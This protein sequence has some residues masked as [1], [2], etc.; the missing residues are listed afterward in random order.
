MN[1]ISKFLNKPAD[2]ISKKDIINFI[3]VKNIRIINFRYIAQDGRLKTLNFPAHDLKYVDRILSV[4]ERV[5][6]SS[7]FKGISHSSSDLYVVPLYQTVF[8]NPFYEVPAIDII[9]NFFN[10]DGNLFESAPDNI[11]RKAVDSF[12]NKTGYDIQVFGELEY[13]VISQRNDLYPIM[14]Q[15]GYHESYPFNKWEFLRVEALDLISKTGAAVKYAHSEVGF[16]RSE[17]KEMIQNEIEFLP[18]SPI[19]AAYQLLIAKWIL[20]SLGNKYGVIVS[21]APKISIG[22]AGSGLHIHSCITKNG[23][24]MMIKN[25]TLSEEAKKLIY[26]MLKVA[27]SSTA[28]GN[29][30]PTSYLRLVP[31]QEAPVKICWG[32][33][34]R[35]ALVRVP[36]GFNLDKNIVSVINK[37]ADNKKYSHSQTVEFRAGDGSAYIPLFIASLVCGAKYGFM[38]KSYNDVEKY[39]ISD[40]TK[41]DFDRLP[42]SCYESADE[43]IKDRSIYEDD[44]VFSKEVIELTYKKLKSYDDKN[45]NE[46]LYG[47]EEEIKKIVEQY[48]YC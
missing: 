8:E 30:F 14:A 11:L 26:G 36:L 6:G 34:N 22:H 20:H 31:G 33:R 38:D 25:S 27:K 5:D 7:L 4:G 12:K 16:I 29:I 44:A 28:F 9:C 40:T 17:D 1:T 42:S 48:L 43:L 47:K 39:Y 3:K 41:S 46:K 24:N 13:Y 35:N 19:S 15:K 23:K 2:N 37:I 45:L 18:Q 10:K 32:Y 21:F